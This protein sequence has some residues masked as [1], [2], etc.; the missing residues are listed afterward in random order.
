M[1]IDDF[2]HEDAALTPAG[3]GMEIEDS[4]ATRQ[5]ERMDA[6]A[7][8]TSS[9]PIKRHKQQQPQRLVPQSVPYAAQF[10]RKPDE[11]GYL[12]RHVRKTSIDD[13][14]RVSSPSMF[15][16]S[17]ARKLLIPSIPLSPPSFVVHAASGM[18][19]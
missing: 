4:Q 19:H 6:T 13:S 12:A 5:P 17:T 3:I 9:I 10:S 1:S 8:A 14:R 16:L 18:T 2:F 15:A 7:T 11:F